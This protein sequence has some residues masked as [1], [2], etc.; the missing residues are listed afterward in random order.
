MSACEEESAL[1]FK[2]VFNDKITSTQEAEAGRSLEFQDGQGYVERS[3]L[4]ADKQVIKI[5][6]SNSRSIKQ[7]YA[8]ASVFTDTRKNA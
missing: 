1:L 8:D 4:K 3:C 7:T 2:R 6:S 5:K